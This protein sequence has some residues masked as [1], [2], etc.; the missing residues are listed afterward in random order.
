[1]IFGDFV[2]LFEGSVFCRRKDKV[3]IYILQFRHFTIKCS[4]MRSNLIFLCKTATH[5]H[6]SYR[7][8]GAIMSYQK[9]SEN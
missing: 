6:T 3:R 5:T 7:W 8:L 1:M 4:E 9:T 2:S